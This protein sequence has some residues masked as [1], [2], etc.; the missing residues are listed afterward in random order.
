[1]NNRVFDGLLTAWLLLG[2][3]SLVIAAITAAIGI[4]TLDGDMVIRGAG[5]GVWA[6]FVEG[7]ALAGFYG[8]G[9]ARALT[10]ESPE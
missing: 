6:L 8:L 7:T 4:W 1:M 2:V 10:E 9:L 3:A 5:F